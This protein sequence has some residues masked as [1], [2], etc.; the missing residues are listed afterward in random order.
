MRTYGRIYDE[1]GQPSWVEVTTDANGYNDAVWITTLVQCLKLSIN[2]S[3]FFADWGIPAQQ[4]VVT[5]V[6]PDYYVTMMQ[7]KFSQY[8]ASL[9]ITKVLGTAS[10]TYNVNII[11]NAG[12]K[13]SL[14]VPG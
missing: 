9:L 11:T 5:Q 2:E 3:P 4:S 7:Q 1:F 13:V 14:K 8:F 10:P 6:Q 12:A